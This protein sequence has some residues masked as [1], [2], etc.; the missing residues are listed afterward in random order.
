MS[1]S[2]CK[3][4]YPSWWDKEGITEAEITTLIFGVD[5]E[6]YERCVMLGSKTD[7]TQAEKKRMGCSARRNSRH[8]P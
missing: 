1:Q 2:T 3:P 6:Q 8:L 4:D 5:P 7:R